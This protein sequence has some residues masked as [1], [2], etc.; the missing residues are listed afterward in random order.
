MK[1]SL[2][3]EY[4]LRALIEL[5]EAKEDDIVPIQLISQRQQ[6]PKRFLEQILND[7]R[8]GDFVESKRGIAGGYRLGRPAQDISLSEVVQHIEGVFLPTTSGSQQPRLQ[9]GALEAQKAIHNTIKEAQDAA[10]KVLESITLQDLLE[11]THQ[12]RDL[13]QSADY[14]I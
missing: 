1:L 9:P 4:A 14:A 13:E 7:L 2:R 5:A 8:S 10:T 11:R 6:I 12:L 3:G